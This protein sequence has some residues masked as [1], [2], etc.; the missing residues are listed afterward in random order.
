MLFREPHKPT[1]ADAIWQLVARDA[2]AEIPLD[3]QYV[4]D[5]GALVQRIPWPYAARYKDI[6]RQYIHYISKRY[7][8]QC[9]CLMGMRGY[10]PRTWHTKDVPK[11]SL[12]QQLHS[13]RTWMPSW[14]R[15]TSWATRRTSS[16]L[17][18][19]WAKTSRSSSVYHPAGDADV[20]IVQK[21]MEWSAT[22]NT[23]LVGDDTDLL[24]LLCYHASLTLH[25]LFFCPELKKNLKKI[26]VWN[27]KS[28]KQQLG[29]E[30]CESILFVHGIQ[31]CDATSHL[32]RIGKGAFLRKS[33]ANSAFCKQAKVFNTPF[34]SPDDVTAAGKKDFWPS[35]MENQ[36][37]PGTH[38][39]TSGFVR[40]LHPSHIMSNHKSYHRPQQQHSTTA[41]VCT[42]QEWR[43]SADSFLLSGGG[44]NTKE[45]SPMADRPSPC[46]RKALAGY[47]VQLWLWLQQPE[48]H[49]QEACHWMH[50]CMR[51]LQ[52]VWMHKCI[53]YH[54]RRWWW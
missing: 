20:L 39:V 3:V 1:L 47:Q 46:A 53:A 5:G 14:I 29:S 44:R 19:C 54:K 48:V 17:S 50:T 32:P 4:L 43:G 6:R 34:A 41:C 33:K 31:G 27:I 30:L 38:F 18:T 2:W 51:K 23:V 40:R 12:V 35:T 37:T 45:V 7:G 52:E 11:E 26:R 22:T 16:S 25:D 49:M 28:I 42:C 10:L 36:L 8:R 13:Q 9:L 24:I 15:N 21:A